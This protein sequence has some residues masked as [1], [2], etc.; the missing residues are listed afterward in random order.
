[1][2]WTPFH[3]SIYLSHASWTIYW[4]MKEKV[5]VLV[6]LVVSDFM[7]LWTIACLAPCSYNSPGKNTGVGYHALLQ[8]IF[9]TQGMNMGLLPC[10]QILYCLSHKG[11]PWF[12]VWIYSDLFNSVSKLMLLYMVSQWASYLISNSVIPI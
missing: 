8:E 6:S 12:I 11:N 5:K 2:I 4:F 9:P 7:T 3:K 1:M 10:R